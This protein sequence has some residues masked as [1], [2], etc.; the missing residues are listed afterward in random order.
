MV[1]EVPCFPFLYFGDLIMRKH[2]CRPLPGDASDPQGLTALLDRFL[3]WMETHHYA[4]GTV[5]VRR[6][7][8]SH[9]LRWCLERCLTRPHD[10]TPEVLERFQRHVYY[11]RKRNGQPLCLSSQSHR[12]TSLRRWFAWLVKQR[13]LEHDPARDLVLPREEQRLPRHPLLVAEVEAVLAQAD[14]A[15]PHGL[16]NRATLEVLYSSGLRRNEALGLEHTDL[17]RERGTLLVRSGKGKKDRFVPIGARALAW[18]DKY[19]AEARPLLA[20]HAETPLVFV[21]KNGRRLHANQ[22]SKIVRDYLNSAGIAKPGACHLFRHATATLML[23]AGADV[24]YIQALLG[25][26]RLSTTQIYTHVS[27][28]KLRE[29]HERTHPARLF[30][31]PGA[32]QPPATDLPDADD[33][34]LEWVP[35]A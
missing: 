7:T 2:T 21:T 27:I 4:S 16:R 30:R 19:L 8:L 28:T 23:E 12:L 29:V 26:T 10:V 14:L 9:F 34:G 11:Y 6:V 15:T 3:L 22:L 33:D 24:R 25:H 17:D 35:V 5:A 18:I 20:R 13:V 1:R 31:V 32:P